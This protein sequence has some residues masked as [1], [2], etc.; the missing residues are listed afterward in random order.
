MAVH[1]QYIICSAEA[2]WWASVLEQMRSKRDFVYEE[3]V[4]RQGLMNV[5]E[6]LELHRQVLNEGEQGL[7]QAA[8]EGWVER[9]RQVRALPLRWSRLEHP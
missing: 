8:I 6:G 5:V 1:F 7:L 9:G 4:G 2:D 3:R